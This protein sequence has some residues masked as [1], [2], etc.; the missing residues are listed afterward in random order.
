MA[1]EPVQPDPGVFASMVVT[2]ECEVI[3]AAEVARRAEAEQKE[4]DR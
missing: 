3:P 1:D 4:Q 2:G